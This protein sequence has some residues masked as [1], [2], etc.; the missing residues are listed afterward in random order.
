M[1]KNGLHPLSG[2]A[3]KLQKRDQDILDAYNKIDDVVA[4]IQEIRDDVE[5][6]FDFGYEASKTLAEIVG[7]SEDV[8]RVCGRQSLRTNVPLIHQSNI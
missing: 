7:S 5:K 3:S 8:P 1:L 6:E 4:G 2:L